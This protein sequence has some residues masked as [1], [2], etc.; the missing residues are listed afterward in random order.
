VGIVASTF[1]IS[2]N[3]YNTIQTIWKTISLHP[4]LSIAAPN[5]HV[6]PHFRCLDILHWKQITFRD[7]LVLGWWG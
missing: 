7:T 3:H 1:T 6:T 5:L 2:T 4:W